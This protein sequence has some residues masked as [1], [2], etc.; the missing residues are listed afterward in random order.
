MFRIPLNVSPFFWLFAL[1]IGWLNSKEPA[2]I[3]I[4]VFIIFISILVHELG[5]A[6]FGLLFNQKVRIEI[7]PFGGVTLREGPKLTLGKEF[8][9]VL[10]GPVFGFSLFLL[11]FFTLPY[12]KD[13]KS[14]FYFAL[15]ILMLVNLLWT[16]L[17]LVPVI[18]LDGGHLLRITME[19]FFGFKG[20]K[21]VHWISFVLAVLLTML[22]FAFGQLFIGI[23]FF[24]LAFSSYRLLK[25]VNQMTVEDQDFSLQEQFEEAEKKLI[26]GNKS[27][28]L[29]DFSKIRERTQ[30][31]M[32]YNIATET[33]AIMMLEDVNLSLD[34]KKEIY[35]LL[36]S[37]PKLSQELVPTLHRL[38]F[39]VSK[40]SKVIELADEAFQLSPTSETALISAMS[41][42]KLSQVKPAVGWLEC[43]L[44]EADLNPDEIIKKK[45][46]DSI[47]HSHEF[48]NLFSGDL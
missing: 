17:N 1:L 23:L 41:Y 19:K 7:A 30:E 20:V 39:E 14:L 45:E 35:S 5:H 37:L 48:V 12:I 21:G 3:I 31:G 28:A 18:P 42:A 11:G 10:A 22:S 2:Q 4:W 46:F 25:N 43:A 44:S 33:Q 9:V 15:H 24:M 8:L 13:E 6:L 29:K 36:I 16:L 38:S 27:E 40:F 32:I 47:R 26:M 34:K